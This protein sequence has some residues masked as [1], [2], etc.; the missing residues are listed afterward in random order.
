MEDKV[1]WFIK[2]NLFTLSKYT[3]GMGGT[4]NGY[5]VVPKGNSYF[6]REYDDVDISIHGGWTFGT[7]AKELD[8]EEL[9]DEYKNDNYWVF[10]WDSLHAGDNL[11]N[12]SKS[13]V[14]QETARAAMDIQIVG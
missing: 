6:G 4:H 5:V 2:E 8:W 12:W 3:R 7:S 14:E 10:G 13:R 11:T 1:D 9:K